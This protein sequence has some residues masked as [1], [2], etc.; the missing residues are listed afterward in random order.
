MAFRSIKRK[1]Y[2]K[3]YSLFDEVKN[4]IIEYL[5]SEKVEK[6]LFTNFNEA[7]KKYII[8]TEDN[9]NISLNNF[10]NIK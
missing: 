7:I 5:K 1:T 9:D 6:T 8:Y 4:D 10:D 2:S 3:I